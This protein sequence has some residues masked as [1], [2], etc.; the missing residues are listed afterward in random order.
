MRVRVANLLGKDVHEAT[1][2]EVEDELEPTGKKWVIEVQGGAEPLNVDWASADEV[3]L[4][5]AT[6]AERA[7]HADMLEKQRQVNEL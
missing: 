4:V 6:D 5:E 7:A 2:S 1:M 3:E